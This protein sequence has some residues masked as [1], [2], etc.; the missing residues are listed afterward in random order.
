MSYRHEVIGP[1]NGRFTIGFGSDPGEREALVGEVFAAIEELRQDGPTEEEIATEK[2]LQYRDLE[3][4]LEQ[5]GFWMGSLA[6]LWIRERP[7]AEMLNRRLR[8]DELTPESVHRAFR[9][10]LPPERYTWL[11]WIPEPEDAPDS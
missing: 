1:G 7:L 2:E 5:N 11:D 4:A 10:Y 3:T 9:E 8:I 6:A